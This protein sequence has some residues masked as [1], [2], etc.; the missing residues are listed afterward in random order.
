MQS[1][2]KQMGDKDVKNAPCS[3][4]AGKPFYPNGGS[5]QLAEETSGA[6]ALVSPR[7]SA[8]GRASTRWENL[9]KHLRPR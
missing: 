2:G 7:P 3:H 1:K 9:R 8:V 6:C 4:R 5:I